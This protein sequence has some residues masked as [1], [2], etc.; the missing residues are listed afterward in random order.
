MDR[1]YVEA[2]RR[3]EDPADPRIGP[4]ATYGKDWLPEAHR[5]NV[6]LVRAAAS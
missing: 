6:R 1:A 3:G 2:L 4:D 5:E